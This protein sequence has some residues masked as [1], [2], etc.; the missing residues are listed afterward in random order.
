M[1]EHVGYARASSYSQDLAIQLE[2]L[3]TVGVKSDNIFK[4]KVSGKSRQGRTELEAMLKFVRKGDVLVVTRVDRLARSLRD[5]Q[6][7]AHQLEEKGV[8][9]KVIEQAVDTTTPGGRA[10]FGML[11]VFAE[12]ENSVRRERQMEGI[13]KAK[14]EGRMN[15]RPVKVDTAKVK[16]LA[17]AGMAKTEIAKELSIDRSSVYRVLSRD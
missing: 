12:F 10:F 7:I 16:D 6:N 8:A 11:G 15:G 17:A 4:E 14:A 3:Q 5:L 13:A 9:L 2:A 1:T